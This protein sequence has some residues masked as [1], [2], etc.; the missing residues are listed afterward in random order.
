MIFAGL[1]QLINHWKD[2]CPDRTIWPISSKYNSTVIARLIA[3]DLEKLIELEARVN[4]LE[5]L[6]NNK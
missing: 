1:K 2:I 6:I 3:E 5:K 4:K